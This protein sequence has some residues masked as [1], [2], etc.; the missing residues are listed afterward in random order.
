MMTEFNRT[1]L[2]DFGGTKHNIWRESS[3]DKIAF[4]LCEGAYVKTITIPDHKAFLKVTAETL[5]SGEFLEAYY[6]F[7]GD[8][9]SAN[10]WLRR[11]MVQ[12]RFREHA[13]PDQNLMDVYEELVKDK[14]DVMFEAEISINLLGLYYCIEGGNADNVSIIKELGRSVHPTNFEEALYFRKNP[15]SHLKPIQFI[16]TLMDDVLSL[17]FK[18]ND[19]D[20]VFETFSTVVNFGTLGDKARPDEIKSIFDRIF[21]RH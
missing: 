19:K 17:G 9:T 3:P 15:E 4:H 5:E 6:T 7:M 13:S 1:M 18:V 11:H 2:P 8:L 16:A 14:T 21:V 12:D 20:W 10:I